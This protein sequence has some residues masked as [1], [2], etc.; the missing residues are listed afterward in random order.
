MHHEKVQVAEMLII[1]ISP[2][3]KAFLMLIV[4]FEGVLLVS[5]YAGRPLFV[6]VVYHTVLHSILLHRGHSQ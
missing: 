5:W 6:L 2:E 3:V 1:I 4:I